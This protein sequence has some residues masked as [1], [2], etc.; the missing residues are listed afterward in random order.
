MPSLH[1]ED[2]ARCGPKQHPFEEKMGR[3]E[4]RGRVHISPVRERVIVNFDRFNAYCR[5]FSRQTGLRLVSTSM[6]ATEFGR[7]I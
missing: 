6:Q 2:A 1:P 4:K 7:L 3:E 5:T